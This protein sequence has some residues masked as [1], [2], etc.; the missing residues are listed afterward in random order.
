MDILNNFRSNVRIKLE[1]LSQDTF[2]NIFIRIDQLGV[3][4][5][6][7]KLGL[8]KFVEHCAR[9]AA[10]T[11]AI[12]GG[13]GALT[14]AIGVPVDLLNMITQQFRVTL[15]TIYYHRGSYSMNFDEFISI[16]AAVFQVEAGVTITKT[17]MERIAEK[18]M[19]RLGSK[20]AGRL[21]PVVGAVIGGT[22]NYMFIKRVAESVKKLERNYQP[23]TIHVE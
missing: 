2:K 18:M 15:G 12:S 16:L 19:I 5:G 22:T 9:L 4:Q 13:G 17:I 3:K 6:V 14:M 10:T 1:D 11:G 7:D 8:D 20:A 23:L 21:I